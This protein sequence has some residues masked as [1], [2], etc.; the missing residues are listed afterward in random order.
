MYKALLVALA[1]SLVESGQLL[2]E[3]GPPSV[4][5]PSP[6]TPTPGNGTTP[7]ALA[8]CP[9]NPDCS[10]LAD[11]MNTGCGAA[12]RFWGSAEYLLW[13]TKNAPLPVPVVTTGDPAVGFPA[14]NTAGAIGSPGT[15]VLLGDSNVNF[16]GF[17]G[18]RIT[19][20]G[21]IDPDRVYGVEVSGFLLQDLTKTFSASS[22]AAGTPALYF[23]RFDGAAGIQDAIPISDPLR[24]FSGN[25][26]AISALELWGVEANNVFVLTSR[27]GLEIQGLVGFR[28]LDLNESFQVNNSTT[29]LIFHDTTNLQ[30]YFGTSNQFYGAQVG[31]RARMEWDRWSLD[32]TGQVALGATVQTVNIQGFISR[33]G[34][35]TFPGGFYTQPSNIGRTTNADF[36]VIPSVDLNVGYRI[37]NNLGVFMGFTFLY[38]NSVVRPGDQIDRNIN[39]TQNALLDPNGVGK[40]VG[41]AAPTPLFNRTDFWALGLNFG[42]NFKF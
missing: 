14:L 41:P 29:D 13:W 26:R 10:P 25:V 7:S 12:S 31:A 19:L 4:L 6:G 8:D 40:L 30:D 16:G 42:L 39:L 15:R 9:P 37:T 27:P 28:N 20:G 22:N 21:W 24:A 35:G 33:P 38:W 36:G 23:P 11:C 1:V 18:L 2:A 32:L 5:P 34:V 3:T 17:S